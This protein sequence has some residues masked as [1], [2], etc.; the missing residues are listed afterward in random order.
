MEEAKR[1]RFCSVIIE[2]WKLL[3]EG[4]A[5]RSC[6]SSTENSSQ[7]HLL[8]FQT[9]PWEVTP[10]LS[11][12]VRRRSRLGWYCLT[13][14]LHNSIQKSRKLNHRKHCCCGCTIVPVNEVHACLKTN[15]AVCLGCPECGESGWHLWVTYK[16]G[17]ARQQT[18][19]SDNLTK[20][21]FGQT[22]VNMLLSESQVERMHS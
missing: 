11:F 17:A 5:S 15:L 10:P 6:C 20:G 9:H 19:N 18:S 2:R 1:Q 3:W 22:L 7:K 8:V 4:T 16:R 12:A 14:W 21:Q 13:R